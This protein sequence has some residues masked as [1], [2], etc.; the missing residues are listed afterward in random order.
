MCSVPDIMI[1][2]GGVG[3]V[4]GVLGAGLL[5]SLEDNVPL[6]MLSYTVPIK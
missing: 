2:C 1:R 3:G 4:G 6:F 5:L